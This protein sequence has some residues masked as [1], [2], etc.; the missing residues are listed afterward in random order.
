MLVEN[1][2]S[3]IDSSEERGL[4]FL[5][6]VIFWRCTKTPPSDCLPNKFELEVILKRSGKKSLAGFFLM[7]TA[8]ITS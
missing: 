7:M 1:K 2:E 3:N 4:F 8:N 6:W 5:A